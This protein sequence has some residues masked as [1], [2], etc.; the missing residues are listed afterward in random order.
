MA[1]CFRPDMV[2]R[3]GSIMPAGCYYDIHHVV[4]GIARDFTSDPSV[5]AKQYEYPTAGEPVVERS[6]GPTSAPPF[7]PP[8][9]RPNLLARF[10]G[11]K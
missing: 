8:T 3:T 6:G 2:F 4:K 9:K 11:A 5:V 1:L 10:F 7:V